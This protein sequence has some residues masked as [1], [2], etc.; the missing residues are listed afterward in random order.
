MKS[1]LWALVALALAAS[2]AVGCGEDN[3]SSW[4]SSSDSS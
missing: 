3:K 4:S 1:K 2:V